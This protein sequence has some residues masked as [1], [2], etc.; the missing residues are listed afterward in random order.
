MYA[1]YGCS[2]RGPACR[3]ERS[4][5]DEWRGGVAALA[6]HVRHAAYRRASRPAYPLMGYP[7]NNL[8]LYLNDGAAFLPDRATKQLCNASPIDA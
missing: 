3:E 7:E 6:V 8:R 1:D 2:P 5:G 4:D